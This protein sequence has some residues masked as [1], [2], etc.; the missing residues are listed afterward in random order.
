VAQAAE[1]PASI[2]ADVAGRRCRPCAAAYTVV[3]LLSVA[4][5]AVTV[6]VRPGDNLMIHAA[7]AI[8]KPGGTCWSS[9]AV[10]RPAR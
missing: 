9:M 4:G 3:A 8:A 6:E 10:M 2:L 1:F 5:P 7:M